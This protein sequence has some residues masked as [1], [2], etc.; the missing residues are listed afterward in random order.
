MQP[1]HVTDAL[2]QFMLIQA[3]QLGYTK[4]AVDNLRTALGGD[5]LVTNFQYGLPVGY[6]I[7]EAKDMDAA[8]STAV[9]LPF[10]GGIGRHAPKSAAGAADP[11]AP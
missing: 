9:A 8:S 6:D 1:Q 3:V 2:R 4:E 7:A 10:V 5:P 11:F